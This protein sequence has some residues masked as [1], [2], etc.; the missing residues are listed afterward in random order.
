MFPEPPIIGSW[1][2]ENKIDL[3][4]VSND[5]VMKQLDSD[6]YD[7][8]ASDS[9]QI[10]S[11]SPP[12]FNGKR[13]SIDERL[14]LSSRSIIFLK[15][16]IEYAGG[17]FVKSDVP[18]TPRR[19]DILITEYRDGKSYITASRNNL[20]VGNLE[21]L[22]YMLVHHT[23]SLATRYLLH[24]PRVRGPL[25]GMENNVI[26]AT[27]YTG[28]SRYYLSSLIEALGAKFTKPFR[29]INTHLICSRRFGMKYDAASQWDVVV[30]NHLWL[31]DSY[32]K[33]ELQ[34]VSHPRYA[35]LPTTENTVEPIGETKLDLEVLKRFYEDEPMT[36]PV[37]VSIEIKENKKTPKLGSLQRLNIN[38][39]PL[40]KGNHRVAVK[41]IEKTP[42]N[43]E[44][45][46]VIN[47]SDQNN[48]K[49]S[50]YGP[51]VL[52]KTP[53]SIPTKRKQNTIETP[54]TI[55]ILNL[56]PTSGEEYHSTSRKAKDKAVRKLHEDMVDL[57]LYLK[58][59][60]LK[61]HNAP[62]LP[63]EIEQLQKIKQLES[64][65]ALTPSKR[66]KSSKHNSTDSDAVP[67]TSSPIRD[68]I[69]TVS[70]PY[71][72]IKAIITG[73]DTIISKSQLNHLTQFGIT[74]INDISEANTL[75]A[76]RVCRTE[77]FLC[78]LRYGIDIISTSYLD[79]VLACFGYHYEETQEEMPI[80]ASEVTKLYINSKM[81]DTL[82]LDNHKL[83]GDEQ[84]NISKSLDVSRNLIK[85]NKLLFSGLTFNITPQVN[86][87][88]DVVSRIMTT[89]GAKVCPIKS[90][91]TKHFQPCLELEHGEKRYIMISKPQ[92]RRFIEMF[93]KTLY[94]D[95]KVE[96]Y[97]WNW[98]CGAILNMSLD[99]TTD[100]FV[101]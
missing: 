84:I 52:P 48:N 22:F 10:P 58:Q 75:F 97:D 73:Y 50:P 3:S 25:K 15:Q 98:A 53:L 54:S 38:Q 27:N 101:L 92:D 88:I 60:K 20:H 69:A 21:W 42:S 62:L 80:D 29:P 44:N 71:V 82:K 67:G 26:S 66:Y 95:N 2:S 23:F 6:I 86:G 87:G 41:Q 76:P 93:K 49:S 94:G 11:S 34:D 56:T 64:L 13:F 14:N 12:F 68:D 57:N 43:K 89:H 63:I 61:N 28:D 32:A 91:R 81:V 65:N 30:V 51:K 100:E 70:M 31:E 37:D 79:I 36:D 8:P 16:A 90:A 1:D 4:D 47:T 83:E 18:L 40:I 19:V 78:S 17:S 59:S 33:W 24:Y 96:V 55:S 5:E 72:N 85:Q 74:I 35:A 39:K 45:N 77:K 7:F 46:E 9:S 99:V